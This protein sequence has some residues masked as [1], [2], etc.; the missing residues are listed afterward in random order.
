MSAPGLNRVAMWAI[1]KCEM[2]RFSRSS[3]QSILSPVLTTSLY[4]IVFGIVAETEHQRLARI[5]E[6]Q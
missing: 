1:Y 2:A 5:R 3:V 6:C 4:F